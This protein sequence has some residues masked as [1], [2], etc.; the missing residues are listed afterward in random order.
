MSNISSRMKNF[1]HGST[2]QQL[3]SLQIRHRATFSSIASLIEPANKSQ[4]Y[5]IYNSPNLALTW[6]KCPTSGLT[7]VICIAHPKKTDIL[8]DLLSCQFIQDLCHLDLLPELLCSI[9]LR[10]EVDSRLSSV[11]QIVRQEVY[12]TGH[13]NLTCRSERPATGDLLRLSAEMSGCMAN[14]ESNIRKGWNLARTE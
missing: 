8:Q 9:F 4:T 12:R 11:K 14:I 3:L 6:S 1:P 10:Q 7:S 13:H 2:I 5:Y